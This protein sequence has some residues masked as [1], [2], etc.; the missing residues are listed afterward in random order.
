[1]LK[2]EYEIQLNENGR[3]C[4]ELSEDYEDKAEDKFFAIEL[5]RYYLQGVHSRMSSEIYDQHT[6]NVMDDAVRLL[7]QIGDEM[8]EIQYDGMRTQG[9]LHLMV[10]SP[11]H[12]KVNSIEER[13]ELPDK[14][15]VYNERLYDRQEG[16][17]VHIQ[18]YDSE[19]YLPISTIYELKDGIT[20]ENWVKL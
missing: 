14:D 11:Y 13:D 12:I 19:T 18:T 8:A 7:G 6:F 20:N 3:P 17:R 2:I 9:E 15:I 1:M 10:G 4:I 5:A 16:L